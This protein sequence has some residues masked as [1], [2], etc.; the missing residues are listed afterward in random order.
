MSKTEPQGDFAVKMKQ[1]FIETMTAQAEVWRAQIKDYQAATE[2]AGKKARAEYAKAIAQMEARAQEAQK[3]S[4][5]IKEA[6]EAAWNDMREA[7]Q[8]ALADM[9]RGWAEA[10]ARFQQ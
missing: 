2:D 9:Q 1:D 5:K 8:K 10:I 7:S 4:A 6:N 3:L